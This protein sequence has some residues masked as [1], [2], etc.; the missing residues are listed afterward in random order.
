M[1]CKNFTFP[2]ADYINMDETLSSFFKQYYLTHIPPN[3]IIS[4]DKILDKDN[5]ETVINKKFHQ[6]SKIL[7][8]N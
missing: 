1:G 5:I 4:K 2:K 6:N 8:R 7:N 3:I